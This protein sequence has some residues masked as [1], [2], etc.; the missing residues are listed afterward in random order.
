[1]NELYIGL[2]GNRIKKTKLFEGQFPK[3]KNF[4]GDLSLSSLIFP[5]RIVSY[6]ELISAYCN[7]LKTLL[8]LDDISQIAH[9]V[10]AI[11]H[12][13]G[14]IVEKNVFNENDKI[15]NLESFYQNL[16]PLLLR[17]LIDSEEMNSG[18]AGTQLNILRDQKEAL[19]ITIEQE[20]YY[21]SKE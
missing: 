11:E 6:Q 10:F 15:P 19:R 16:S 14:I 4:V 12:N 5:N 21:W 18:P 2:H 20:L 9:G 3:S 7:D 13:I 8:A 1:M 17:V